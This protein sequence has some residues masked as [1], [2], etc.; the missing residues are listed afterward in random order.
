MVICTLNLKLIVILCTANEL[1]AS[2]VS[3]EKR[4][5]TQPFKRPRY[6]VFLQGLSAFNVVPSQVELQSHGPLGSP[7]EQSSSCMKSLFT[8]SY[9][10][11]F[12]VKGLFGANIVCS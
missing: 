10:T 9:L 2:D 8:H 3:T 1:N 7:K 12:R 4:A 5:A 6:D 11:Q